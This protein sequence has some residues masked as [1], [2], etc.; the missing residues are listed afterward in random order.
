MLCS[1]GGPVWRVARGKFACVVS[2]V[3][4]THVESGYFREAL[5]VHEE[6]VHVTVEVACITELTV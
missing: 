2:L 3:T 5:S 6:L 1:F 4:T